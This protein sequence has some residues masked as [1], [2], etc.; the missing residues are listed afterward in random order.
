MTNAVYIF[1][2]FLFFFS[3]HS[4]RYGPIL[5]VRGFYINLKEVHAQKTKEGLYSGVAKGCGVEVEGSRVR[6]CKWRDDLN[7]TVSTSCGYRGLQSPFQCK[8]MAL[9]HAIATSCR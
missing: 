6:A 4:R 8:K 1:L 2:F 7:M 3:L 5:I 9:Q